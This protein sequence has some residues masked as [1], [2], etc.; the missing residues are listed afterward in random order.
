M[1]VEMVAGDSED[2]ETAFLACSIK[3]CP[4]VCIKHAQ[5]IHA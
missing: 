1:A 5:L 2:V 3:Q 4:I